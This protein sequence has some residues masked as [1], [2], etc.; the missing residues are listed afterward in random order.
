MTS[1]EEL[2]LPLADVADVADAAEASGQRS[3]DQF[4]A[5]RGDIVVSRSPSLIFALS[6]ALPLRQRPA[7]RSL[8]ACGG[9]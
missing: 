6:P 2:P 8:R 4:E 5:L 7:A 3:I 9:S 1:E